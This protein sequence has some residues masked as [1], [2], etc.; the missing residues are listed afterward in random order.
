ML[1]FSP[2][3]KEWRSPFCGFANH[4][5][6][7]SSAWL[8]K[9]IGERFPLSSEERAGVRTSVSQINSGF[10]VCYSLR[11]AFVLNCL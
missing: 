2:G 10:G 11:V 3:E 6:T 9:M 8:F 4:R 7:N 1:A 5:V